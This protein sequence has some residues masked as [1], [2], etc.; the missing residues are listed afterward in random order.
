M[1]FLGSLVY[2]QQNMMVCH[3]FP[4]PENLKE[5]STEDFLY[6][7]LFFSKGNCISCVVE[8]IEILNALPSQKFRIF[9]I[10]PEEEL[11][12]DEASLRRTTGAVFPLFAS[13][14]YKQYLP[15]YTPT[16]F[17]VSPSGKIILVL[18]GINDQSIYLKGILS[19]LYWK[20]HSSS[21]RENIDIVS[22]INKS[23][24]N[25]P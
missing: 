12:K 10:V 11:I 20:L 6:I 15:S 17:G 23:G 16:I 1:V 8:I 22:S 7:F 25:R 4:V 9:G 21:K 13:N 24:G 3:H 2:K 19:S 18:P 5:D 14:K